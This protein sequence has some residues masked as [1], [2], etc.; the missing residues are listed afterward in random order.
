MMDEYEI[1]Q[2]L[3]KNTLANIKVLREFYA[4]H[5]EDADFESL[6]TDEDFQWFLDILDEIEN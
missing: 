6:L 3:I 1:A 2:N 4:S 5:L